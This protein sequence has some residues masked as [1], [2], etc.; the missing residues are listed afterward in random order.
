MIQ[1]LFSNVIVLLVSIIATILFIE[2]LKKKNTDKVMIKALFLTYINFM[3]CLCV[4]YLLKSIFY[5]SYLFMCVWII[6]S[7]VT[8][9]IF[10]A[11][12][13]YS[14]KIGIFFTIFIISVISL[15]YISY[16]PCYVRQHDMRSFENYQN[17]GHLGYIGYIFYNG[18]LPNVSPKDYW[19]FYNPP[20]FYIICAIFIKL[21]NLFGVEIGLCLENLQG[22]TFIY[23]IVFDIFV[24]KILKQMN[25]K[26]SIIYVLSFVGLTPL[27]IILSGSIGNGTLSVM[28]STIAIY[29]TMRWYDSDSLKDLIKIAFS[30][31]LAIMTKIDSALIAILIAVVFLIKVIKNKSEIKKYIKYFSIFAIISLPIGLWYPIKNLVL[32]DIPFTYVQSVEKD[33]ESNISKYSNFERFF[34]ISSENLNDINITMSGETRDYN[35]PITT[36]KSVIVDENLDYGENKLLNFAIHFIFYISIYIAIAF[37]INLVY[38]VKNYK[39]INNGW[40]CFF[41]GLLLIEI[42]SYLQFCFKFPFVFTMNFRYIIPTLISFAVLT[43][44]ACENNKI[45]FNINKILL[46]T[47]S[48]LSIIIFLLIK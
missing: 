43:G 36:L 3:I 27:M 5:I 22:L 9:I 30:I 6:F 34:K 32:Y 25:I 31:S 45:I 7:I 26:K 38:I 8:I 15:G 2:I 39:E 35:I 37:I 11:L 23:V 24:Y 42:F 33:H 29:Y 47:F 19:C 20:L 40:I 17:G 10:K 14:Q 1:L 12:K 13:L 48:L 4:T 18:R 41:I 21:Q 28:L 44:I 46:T 16:T